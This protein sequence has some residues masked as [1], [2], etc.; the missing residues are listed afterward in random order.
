MSV[1]TNWQDHFENLT[2]EDTEDMDVNEIMEVGMEWYRTALS[3][4]I[5]ATCALVARE[6]GEAPSVRYGPK[7]SWEREG[8]IIYVDDYGK[9]MTVRDARDLDDDIDPDYRYTKARQVC[10]THPC[11]KL[12]IPGDWLEIIA[13]HI[14]P[15]EQRKERR[16]KR[17]HENRRQRALERV[18]IEK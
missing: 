13:P 11:S 14:E 17:R 5:P 3:L 16:E 1:F 15:A 4:N 18:G 7:Y 2:P 12:F 6:L 9:Y 10:S 8:I